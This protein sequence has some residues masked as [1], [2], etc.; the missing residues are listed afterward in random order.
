[1]NQQVGDLLELAGV[2]DFEDVVTAVMQIIAGHPDR[3]QRGVARLDT[4]EG[5]GLLGL[6]PRYGLLYGAHVV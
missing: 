4:G 2:G 5:D 3:T 1:V 6:R